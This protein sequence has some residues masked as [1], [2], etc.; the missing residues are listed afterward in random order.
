MV[1]LRFKQSLAVLLAA[2][3]VGATALGQGPVDVLWVP[4]GTGDYN[5]GTNWSGASFGGVP[6]AIFEERAVIINGGTA[7]LSAP[8]AD[9]P[10][11]V[12]L[13]QA[14]VAGTVG[15]GTL[16]INAGGSLESVASPNTNGNVVVGASTGTGTLNMTGG[17]PLT[18]T[19]SKQTIS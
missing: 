12:S 19:S 2:C 15:T 16:T 1:P 3:S 18:T 6:Q 8:G 7:T 17:S 9:M 10:G 13:G 5:T 11:G 4:T 14:P